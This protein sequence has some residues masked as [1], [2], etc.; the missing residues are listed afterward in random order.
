M[1]EEVGESCDSVV[2]TRIGS[3]GEVRE[4]MVSVN[5]SFE[6]PKRVA[7]PAD[8]RRTPTSLLLHDM[9]LCNSPAYHQS[10]L[11]LY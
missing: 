11:R 8:M 5:R 7:D 1:G 6:Q 9:A 3:A 10:D 4:C 2:E